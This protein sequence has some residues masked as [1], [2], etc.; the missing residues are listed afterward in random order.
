MERQFGGASCGG[1]PLRSVTITHHYLLAVRPLNRVT[2]IPV[3]SSFHLH[4]ERSE[5]LAWTRSGVVAAAAVLV[6]LDGLVP[7]EKKREILASFFVRTFKRFART[8]IWNCGVNRDPSLL[9]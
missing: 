8:G 9:G 2:I 4:T 1:R 7:R 6:K 3:P 5:G